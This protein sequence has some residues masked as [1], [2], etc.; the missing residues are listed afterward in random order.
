LPLKKRFVVTDLH[1]SVISITEGTPVW[2]QLLCL[3]SLFTCCWHFNLVF[4]FRHWSYNLSYMAASSFAP[5]ILHITSMKRTATILYSPLVRPENQPSLDY[6]RCQKSTHC[7]Q[8][9]TAV[10]VTTLLSLSLLLLR[11]SQF[12]GAWKSQLLTLLFFMSLW[13]FLQY[14]I[15]LV[16]LVGY[17]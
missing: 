15:L 14:S 10:M 9:C 1:V 4:D 6:M 2:A 16:L 13:S 3:G 7:R 11:S 5:P 12:L 8:T 17:Y